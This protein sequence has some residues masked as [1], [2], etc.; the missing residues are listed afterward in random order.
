MSEQGRKI[1]LGSPEFRELMAK[2]AAIAAA[3]AA[4][5]IASHAP[6]A[7]ETPAPNA[8]A[9]GI[10]AQ[11][12]AAIP[13]GTFRATAA[14]G[15][16]PET[17]PDFVLSSTLQSMPTAIP[18]VSTTQADEPA[19]HTLESG[20]GHSK[21]KEVACHNPTLYHA[22][23]YL[24][25]Y[26]STV[27]DKHQPANFGFVL[28]DQLP[29]GVSSSGNSSYYSPIRIFPS[30][31][32]TYRSANAEVQRKPSWG[33]AS[34]PSTKSKP[35]EPTVSV[36]QR[37][38][39]VQ[40]REQPVQQDHK[41]SQPEERSAAPSRSA[42]PARQSVQQHAS[43]SPRPAHIPVNECPSRSPRLGHQP[44]HLRYFDSYGALDCGA[45]TL[46][47]YLDGLRDELTIRGLP[48]PKTD[49]WRD[50]AS[51]LAENDKEWRKQLFTLEREVLSK[52]CGKEKVD[53]FM[54]TEPFKNQEYFDYGDL[55]AELIY[56]Y[57]ETPEFSELMTNVLDLRSVAY[58]MLLHIANHEYVSLGT[59]MPDF[60]PDFARRIADF[61]AR[62]I[63]TE[64][65][66]LRQRVEKYARGRGTISPPERSDTAPV[67]SQGRKR[68]RGKDLQEEGETKPANKKPRKNAASVSIE[69]E[70]AAFQPGSAT[71]S[72]PEQSTLATPA[73][74]SPINVNPVST[75]GS[76][77]TKRQG[78]T[79]GE[80]GLDTGK[81]KPRRDATLT[82]KAPTTTQ[83]EAA[84]GATSEQSE[85]EIQPMNR[86]PQQ[87]AAHV[88]KA[89]AS[90]STR[91]RSTTAS[92]ICET[93]Q[94]QSRKTKAATQS[95]LE[96]DRDPS[97]SDTPT[98]DHDSLQTRSI[99]RN[100][101]SNKRKEPEPEYVWEWEDE[102]LS[103]FIDDGDE[104]ESVR[105]SKRK[106]RNS[107]EKKRFDRAKFRRTTNLVK[108]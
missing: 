64:G 18:D 82:K 23:S 73:S 97:E 106:R 71:G 2:K 67:G 90:A 99:K 11:V 85:H 28:S 59:K 46:G 78:D 61:R 105:P 76:K 29:F 96:E 88:D 48:F 14:P 51:V 83:D 91:E 108:D 42:P 69:K 94:A 58:N 9:T 24:S 55:E 34:K 47:L 50:L 31:D 70:F 87:D 5:A 68:R 30:I 37:H 89:S 49:N 81:K 6:V 41:T 100:L 54:R 32:G 20:W 45:Q 107:D 44:V 36:A 84:A 4:S 101:R 43:Q 25:T 93:S 98:G 80:E 7:N 77:H 74:R 13:P 60:H 1:K 27:S 66:P 104:D 57:K 26:S 19:Y 79:E 72:S 15:R 63:A 103:D 3:A 92:S 86:K 65:S 53:A 52:L 10:L 40:H 16:A 8:P 17:A 35:N 39:Y 75:P 12:S 56:H 33:A 21:G 22:V 62:K 95:P 38:K 102:D